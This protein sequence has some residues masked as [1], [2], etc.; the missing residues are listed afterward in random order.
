MFE[1]EQHKGTEQQ[2]HTTS[3]NCTNVNGVRISAKQEQERKKSYIFV[4]K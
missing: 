2:V 3:N 1:W 4:N